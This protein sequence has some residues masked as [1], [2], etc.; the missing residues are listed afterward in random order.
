MKL[1]ND[2]A[3]QLV[4]P[5]CHQRNATER[6][7]G[8]F[9]NKNNCKKER[10]LLSLE[11]NCKIMSWHDK[12]HSTLDRGRSVMHF[13]FTRIQQSAESHD[14]DGDALLLRS[15]IED[16][17][18]KIKM[19]SFVNYCTVGY[20]G[21]GRGI[22]NDPSLFAASTCYR[23]CRAGWHIVTRRTVPTNLPVTFPMWRLSL[24]L[25]TIYTH[26]AIQGF[27]FYC[28]DWRLMVAH[29]RT[30]EQTANYMHILFFLFREMANI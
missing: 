29:G 23:T 26:H 6:A 2:I 18:I 7:I 14:V 28:E 4:P 5:R 24:F 10:E 1:I 27:T 25:P 8:T 20:L 13:H 30:I 19:N 22:R 12:Q 16:R 21:R 11:A 15:I 3:Y 9:N 17:R